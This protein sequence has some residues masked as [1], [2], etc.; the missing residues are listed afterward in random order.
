MRKV[1]V[2]TIVLII[3][4]IL[5]SAALTVSLS[6]GATNFQ[7]IRILADGS[8]EPATAPLRRDGNTY[9]FTGNVQ[10][11]SLVQ[12]AFVI[13]KDNIV[14]DGAGYTLQGTYNGTK[15]IEWTVGQGPYNG[16]E[17]LPWTVGLDI[18]DRSRG[19]LTIKNLNVKNFSIGLFIW[20]SNNTI[21]G[22]SVTDNE[23]GIMI[24]ESSNSIIGN[25]I[26][27]N[28]EGV[29]LA[30]NSSGCFAENMTSYRNSF[31]N[32]IKQVSGCQCTDTVENCTVYSTNIWDNGGEGNYWSDYTGVDNDKDGK[33][34]SPYTIDLKNQDRYPLMESAA[35]LP[36][37]NP[38]FPTTL[39]LTATAG[40]TVAGA[41]LLFY[42]RKRNR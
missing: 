35:S 36:T 1:A 4:L 15:D 26:A 14:I 34:D 10:A 24:S 17:L 21:I 37:A 13:E 16:T 40:V 42:F 41:G 18:A 31:I 29:F 23:V 19:N 12:S 7:T 39:V 3:A 5:F 11:S 20:T 38:E 32:N 28:D 22:N 8:V 2:F 27:N 9:Y 30:V 6:A 33:G 25:Y